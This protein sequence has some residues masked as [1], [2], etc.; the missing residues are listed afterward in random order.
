MGRGHEG[1]GLLVA[2]QDQ[3]DLRTAQ[4]FDEV[5]IFL[6]GN[7]EDAVDAFVLQCCDKEIRSLHRPCLVAHVASLDCRRFALVHDGNGPS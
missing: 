3:F 6:A 4:G 2:G 7:T 5:E 1:G